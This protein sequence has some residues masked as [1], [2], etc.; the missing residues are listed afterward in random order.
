MKISLT[1]ISIGDRVRAAKTNPNGTDTSAVPMEVNPSPGEGSIQPID[2]TGIDQAAANVN[3]QTQTA[4]RATSRTNIQ[5]NNPA[6]EGL[7]YD[8]QTLSTTDQAEAPS[9]SHEITSTPQPR[10]KG[11]KES[12]IDAQLSQRMTDASINSHPAPETNY[13]HEDGDPNEHIGK[14]PE[15]QPIRRDK[16]A[17]YNDSNVKVPEPEAYPISKWEN[18]Q[19][20]PDWNP[21]NRDL[22]P[23]YKD[24]GMPTPTVQWATPKINTPKFK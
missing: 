2:T 16:I 5:Q 9:K 11:F 7:Q 6:S 3:S 21:P 17:P 12:L 18:S 15:S 4:N 24:R 14:Q 10:T 23:Q 1:S 8:K 20:T 19:K 22:G 13:G